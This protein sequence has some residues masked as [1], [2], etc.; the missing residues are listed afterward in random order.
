[1]GSYKV[2]F[3]IDGELFDVKNFEYGVSIVA[4]VV[5]EKT[6]YTFGGWQ[7]MPET[8]PAK[9]IEVRG[10]YTINKYTLNFYIDGVLFETKTVEYNSEIEA[11]E[12]PAK[13][14]HV[15]SGWDNLPERMPANDL[16]VQGSYSKNK[17][18]VTLY[19]DG[20]YY[21]S[22]YVEY[23]SKIELPV[24]ETDEGRQFEG[25]LELPDTMPARDI[26]IHGTTSL[27]E[28]GI[29]GIQ[30]NPEI[31]VDI[32]SLNGMLLH[33]N[34]ELKEFMRTAAPDFYLIKHKDRS[35]KI[36]L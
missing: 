16:H 9:N 2:S 28:T 20:E 34:V 21:D 18:L 11:P 35:Y 6:G 32:Y 33:K 31:R 29:E 4:P 13:E 19:I 7:N 8:M 25:W 17:Y 24:P 26:V 10:Y 27:I 5:E 12:A 22:L 36:R 15:F 23:G 14:G 30:D 3:Y 1:M